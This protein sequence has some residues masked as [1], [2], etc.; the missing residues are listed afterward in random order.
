M[1]PLADVPV[2]REQSLRDLYIF[3]GR[4]STFSVNFLRKII[5]RWAVVWRA[6][7]YMVMPATCREGCR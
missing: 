3:L 7:D 2:G 1:Q 6:A 4:G 5:T